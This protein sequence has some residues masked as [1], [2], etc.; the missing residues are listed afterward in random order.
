MLQS[1]STISNWIGHRCKGKSRTF[2][3]NSS[4][5]GSSECFFVAAVAVEQGLIDNASPC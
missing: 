4:L 3:P 5:D 2:C 1:L